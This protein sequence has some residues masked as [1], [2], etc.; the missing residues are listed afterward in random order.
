MMIVVIMFVIVSMSM[1]MIVTVT[2]TMR[3]AVMTSMRIIMQNLH[4]NQIADK[5]KYTSN[6]HVEWFIYYL[7]SNHSFGCLDEQLCCDNVDYC[8]VN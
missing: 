7:L 3:T 1:S 2:V 4:D 6:E 5:S 8:N